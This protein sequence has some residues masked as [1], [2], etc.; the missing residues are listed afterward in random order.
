[1]ETT[2]Y[3]MN[4]T[5]VSNLAQFTM[6]VLILV[7]LLSLKNKTY[8]TLFFCGF[9]IICSPI[10]Y[11]TNTLNSIY[12]TPETI[13]YSN[14]ALVLTFSYQFYLAYL[15]GGNPFSKELY[16]CSILVVSLIIFVSL[17]PLEYNFR[18]FHFYPFAYI[19]IVIVYLRKAKW[20]EKNL[21]PEKRTFDSS[22]IG[23]KIFFDLLETKRNIKLFRDFAIGS[24][25]SIMS[26]TNVNVFNFILDGG[27]TSFLYALFRDSLTLIIISIYGIGYVTHA[28]ERTSFQ[29]KTIGIILCVVL[30]LFSVLPYVLVRNHRNI[31][32]QQILLSLT[33]L[34]PIFTLIIIFLL[35]FFLHNN[36]FRSLDNIIVSVQEVNKGNLNSTVSIDANDELGLLSQNFNSMTESL[37]VYANQ[38]EKLV[39][40]R[41]NELNQSLI[42]LKSTQ[43]QL[44]QS[45]KLASLGELTA[46]IAH[47]IQNPLNF[48]NN[49]AEMSVSLANELNEEIKNSPLSPDGGII[50]KDK[51]YFEEIIS[52]L[53]QNQEKINYHGKRASSIV[54]GMLQH[55][56]AS[57]GKKE[58]TD[59]N[60]LADESL[61]LSYH[62]LR[63]K[64]K[65]STTNH[66]NSDF[67][68]I[69]DENL[70]KINVIPQDIGRVL[71][72][73]INNAFYAVNVARISNPCVIVKTEK[74]DNQIIIK[75]TDNGTGM[76]EATKAKIFQPFFTTK[77]TGQGTGLGLSLA[78]DIITKGHGGTIECESVEGEGTTFIVKIPI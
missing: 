66:F 21:L 16:L 61:R 52:D 70:P 73:L 54:T 69:I 32:A 59:I 40:Q 60:K 3:L 2:S 75:V 22:K 72:N 23:A 1:M 14:L 56:Q 49:F 45:E 25:V 17:A 36:L 65:N 37:Q 48:V 42:T 11:F 8:N 58:L 30:V 35:P 51:E 44:I 68:L 10:Y 57:S 38:M 13:Q 33:I 26:W 46:G 24:A 19:W 77:P 6:C 31:E 20:Y 50:I 62:G 64:N 18:V 9:F 15:L 39:L 28:K 76:S 74:V 12:H 7:Y 78:Y 47:E 53:T 5:I 41:T 63:A 34:I 55:S 71:I 67:E 29:A 27:S 43:S 4:P